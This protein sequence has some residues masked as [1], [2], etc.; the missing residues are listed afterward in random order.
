MKLSSVLLAGVLATAGCQHIYANNPP[1]YGG[2]QYATVRDVQDGL[3]QLRYYDGPIDGVDG[4]QTR[5]AIQRYQGDRG[6]RPDGVIDARLID[7]I[8]ADLTTSNNQNDEGTPERRVRRVQEAL[9]QLG[10]YRG[11]IDGEIDRDT[12]TAI[13]NY[14]RDRRLPINDEIDRQ[15]IESLQLDVA[16]GPVPNP[17]PASGRFVSGDRLPSN[18]RAVL[19]R[20]WRS[21]EGMLVDLDRDGDLDVI[22]RAGQRSGDC[23]F[24]DCGHVVLRGR[25]GDFIEIG[26]FVASETEV[27]QRSTNGFSDIAYRSAGA[28][29]RG[30]LRFDGRRYRG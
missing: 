23:R 16:S 5:Q 11:R 20:R 13:V 28:Q 26:S 1:V 25:R 8:N 2:A 3:R 22:A 9:S 19:D 21:Y 27:M 18:V 29:Q 17:Y 12:R 7:R 10:Y 15:L 6:M 14:R 24:G 4:P 30:V